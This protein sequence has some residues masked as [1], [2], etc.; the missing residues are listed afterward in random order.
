VTRLGGSMK[1]YVRKAGGQPGTPDGGADDRSGRRAAAPPFPPHTLERHNSRLLHPGTAV[2]IAG[3][4]VPMPTAH[5]AGVLLIPDAVRRGDR[6]HGLNALLADAGIFFDDSTCPRAAEGDSRT[7]AVPLRLLEGAAP[8]VVESWNVLQN[9][10]AA[11]ARGDRRVDPELVSQIGLDH[12]LTGSALGGVGGELTGTNWVTEGS[13]GTPVSALTSSDHGYANRLPVDLALSAPTFT[14]P[15]GGPRRPVVV[16]LDSGLGQHPWFADGSVR[17]RA[18][19]QAAVDA[20]AATLDDGGP[21]ISGGEDGPVTDPTLV[22]ALASHYGHGTFIAGIIRQLA[23]M[24]EVHMVR[25]MHSDGVAYESDLLTALCALLEEARAWAAGDASA[26]PVD[27][28]SLSLGYFHEDGD[29]LSPSLLAALDELTDL[30]VTV[31]SAAGNFGTGRPFY[32][33]GFAP[34]YAERAGAPLLSVG[35][36]N[37][38]ESIALF[39][40]DGAWVNAMATGAAMVSA[41][42]VTAR[43]SRQPDYSLGDGARQGLDPDDY[44]S[45][46]AVWSGTSFAS[47]A[48]AGAVAAQLYQQ[49]GDPRYALAD[50]GAQAAVRRARQAV[51][52]LA[53]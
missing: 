6:L 21:L 48:A 4:P 32:P 7:R 46:F 41:F 43:G 35:A 19:T 8:T 36:L 34:R 16:V 14:A 15:A 30:G 44:S 12:L 3:R 26:E 5:R 42:P 24:A 38:N 53:G 2:R 18:S 39:S 33:A 31:V 28:L 29:T 9:L 25:I 49:A 37:P 40:D 13:G 51:A 20:A 22:G 52:A 47:A 27:V 17:I 10:R 1:V 50:A 11:A 45:G 23:P